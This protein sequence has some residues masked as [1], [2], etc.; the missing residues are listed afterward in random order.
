M[1]FGTDG[2][3]GRWPQEP[4]TAAVVASLGAAL[5]ERFDGPLVVVRDTR[6]SGAAILAAL[7]SGHGGV[8]RDAGVL[9][10][11]AASVLVAAG[12]GSCAVVLTASHNPWQDSGLKVVGPGGRKLSL[13]GE[14]ELDARVDAL[15][16]T[17]PARTALVTPIFDEARQAYQRAVLAAVP[18]GLSLSGCRVAI[19][20]AHGSAWQTA[21]AVLRELGAE[22]V[23]L[24]CAPDGRNINEGVGALHPFGVA[25][26]VQAEDCVAGLALDGDADRAVLVAGS[27]R[28]VDGDALLLLL[29]RDPGVVGTVLCNEA[30]AVALAAQ[31]RELV[32][33]P[34]GDRQVAAELSRRGWP[35]GGEPS[36]HV[37]LADGLP[38]GDGLVTALH[39]WAGGLD[40]DARLAD[41]RPHAQAKATVPVTERPPLAGLAPLQEALASLAGRPVVRYSGTEP[42]LR[43]QIEHP[44]GEVA[45]RELQALLRAVRA[46]GLTE[47]R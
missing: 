38:T 26:A 45:E 34:V 21:P 40:L 7:A 28:V 8:V 3:R 41:W 23:A 5:K 25:A 29:A 31:G 22:V 12:V 32:R 9:P 13:A 17:P 37:L 43:L 30:L 33:T 20:C 6:Q 2:I 14:A 10:T 46:S 36:G 42:K 15:A 44:D 47:Y 35:V 18:N 24:G 27:G 19:D 16:A 1:R 39:V 4:L 11:A